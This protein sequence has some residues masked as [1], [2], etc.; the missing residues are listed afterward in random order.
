MYDIC[1]HGN[2]LSQ[3]PI[4]STEKLFAI[5]CSLQYYKNTYVDTLVFSPLQYVLKDP[6]LVL[7]EGRIIRMHVHIQMKQTYT[8]VK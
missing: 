3:T 5:S 1:T 4:I 2:P 7:F 6:T 8:Y